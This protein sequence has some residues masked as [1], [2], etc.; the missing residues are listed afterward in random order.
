MEVP[1][2]QIVLQII[3]LILQR[4]SVNMKKCCTMNISVLHFSNCIRDTYLKP[5][6]A[7]LFSFLCCVF[8]F[9]CLRS[10]SCVPNVFA[11]FSGLSHLDCAFGLN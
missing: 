9:V 6:V 1:I 8:C 2:I 3:I 11:G 10:V 5:A 4:L 7:H